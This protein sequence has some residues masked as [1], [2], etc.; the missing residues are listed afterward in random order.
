LWLAQSKTCHWWWPYKGLVLVSERHTELHINTEG[1]L[2]RDGGPAVCYSDGWSLYALNG[3]NVPAE[4]A[5]KPAGELAADAR[6]W[7]AEPNVEVRR[8]YIRKVGIESALHAL[9]PRVLDRSPWGPNPDTVYELLAINLGPDV[10]EKRALK[11]LNPSI[12]VWH[13]EGVED[14]IETV[15][16]A[17]NWR[18]SGNKHKP[19]KPAL[20]T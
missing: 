17:H 15:E 8:E 3:V 16:Q 12:K 2:H 9:D 7:I 20:L 19:W 4:L 13:V 14:D 11:M 1:R 6:K 10:G 18:A 5:L